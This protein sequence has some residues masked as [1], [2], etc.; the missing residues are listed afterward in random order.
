MAQVSGMNPHSFFLQRAGWSVLYVGTDGVHAV[1]EQSLDGL[2]LTP[3]RVGLEHVGI[4]YLWCR[5]T[6]TGRT[7]I[8]TCGVINGCSHHRVKA[9]DLQPAGAADLADALGPLE[10]AARGV[11]R[12]GL[13]YCVLAGACSLRSVDTGTS[14]P[15]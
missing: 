8:D 7:R 14:S 10:A 2:D 9:I 12:H 6:P 5:V 4:Q 13:C 11:D 15:C 3:P 1:Y